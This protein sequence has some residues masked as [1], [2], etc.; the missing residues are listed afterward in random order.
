M[1]WVKLMTTGKRVANS[2]G[3]GGG[4]VGMADFARRAEGWEGPS[5]DLASKE[6]GGAACCCLVGCAEEHSGLAV[7]CIMWIADSE[8]ATAER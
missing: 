7:S 6:M 2:D 1:S 3:V 4:L 5:Q 8:L